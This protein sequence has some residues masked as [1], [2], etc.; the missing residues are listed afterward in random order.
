MAGHGCRPRLD[1]GARQRAARRADRG[2]AD[3]RDVRGDRVARPPETVGHRGDRPAGRVRTSAPRGAAWVRPRRLARAP[4]A[5][6]GRPRS[7]GAHPRLRCERTGRERRRRRPRRARAPLEALRTAPDPDGGGRSGFPLEGRH[8]GRAARRRAD[9]PMEPDG[10]ACVAGSGRGRGNGPRRSRTT[11]DRARRP[12]GERREGDGRGERS[13]SSG[14][15]ADGRPA[16]ARGRGRGQGHQRR[17]PPPDLR[18]LLQDRAGPGE[19]GTA[20]RDSGCPSRRRSSMPTVGRSPWR[21]RRVMARPSASACRGSAG[22]RRSIRS[23]RPRP[24]RTA[25]TRRAP[26]RR[27]SRSPPR[28]PP[29]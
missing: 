5:D 26:G 3:G 11:G 14:A 22:P 8:R 10:R 27:P 2:P 18:A 15:R 9:A 17:G 19:D 4:D 21:A 24:I 13:S 12:D 1:R 28:A 23:R 16:R 20:G 6:H 29:R 7:R 25:G